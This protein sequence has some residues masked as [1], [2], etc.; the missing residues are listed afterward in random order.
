MATSTK[1][2][3]DET[4]TWFLCPVNQDGYIKGNIHKETQ[5][6]NRQH[7]QRDTGKKQVTP[8]RDTGK[9]Q[10]TPQRDTGKKPVTPQRDTGKK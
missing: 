10:V 7:P 6:K 4:V 2:H 1:K 5:G 9:K 3:W 8:Q